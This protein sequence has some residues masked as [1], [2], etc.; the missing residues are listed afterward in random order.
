MQIKEFT[1][2]LSKYVGRERRWKVNNYKK[3]YDELDHLNDK[4]KDILTKKTE[5]IVSKLKKTDFKKYVALLSFIPNNLKLTYKS[6]VW[7]KAR[8]KTGK[9]KKK[10][11]MKP[12]RGQIYNAYLGENLGSE[13]SGDHPVIVM[14]NSTGNLFAQKVNVLPIEG[15]GNDV[16]EPYQMKITSADLED[17]VKLTKDPSRIIISDILTIDKARLG[18]KVGMIKEVKMKEINKA[19]IAQLGIDIKDLE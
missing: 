5:S 4:S 19:I 16:T 2:I 14:Q 3:E 18:V 7:N 15:D 11:P 13:L 1:L 17:D 9:D 6:D 12:I 8:P 10:H